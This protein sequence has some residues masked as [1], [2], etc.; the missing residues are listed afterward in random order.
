MDSIQKCSM[1]VVNSLELQQ[2]IEYKDMQLI[3]MWY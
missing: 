2:V 1:E 3:L